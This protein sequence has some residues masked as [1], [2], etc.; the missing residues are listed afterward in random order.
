[1][2]CRGVCLRAAAAAATQDNIIHVWREWGGSETVIPDATAAGYNL[3]INI[4]YRDDSCQCVWC[5]RVRNCSNAVLSVCF[6]HPKPDTTRGALQ[7]TWTTS[8]SCGTPVFF[9]GA[10]YFQ[11]Q[12]FRSFYLTNTQSVG[13][14]LIIFY[15]DC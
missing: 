9:D 14:Q 11:I 15:T 2:R 5:F 6:L 4:G 12:S 7:G 3:I 13:C 10:A 8:K 1:M